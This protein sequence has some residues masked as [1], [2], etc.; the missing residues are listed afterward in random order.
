MR[1]RLRLLTLLANRG[2]LI[3]GGVRLF[4][5]LAAASALAACAG[6]DRNS[7]QAL[8]TAG[9]TAAQA[10]ADQ[11]TAATT[12]LGEL[13]EWFAVGG[14][15]V[16]ANIPPGSTRATCLQNARVA[17]NNPDKGLQTAQQQLVKVMKARADAALA[18][19]DAYQSFVN[20]ATYDAGSE[21]QQAIQNAVGA[22]NELTKAAA[23]IAPQGAALAPISSTF[24]TVT[25]NIGGIIA[26][27]RQ[28]QVM[29]AASKDLHR[30]T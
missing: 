5:G 9:Q 11:A 27:E 2:S 3:G 14:A 28:R 19:R 6:I 18:L 23:A 25:A 26:S 20:L 15:L 7:G 17:A 30:A 12:S 21:T 8:G 24:T 10:M 16:C 22:I 1:K 29:L 4:C 13:T